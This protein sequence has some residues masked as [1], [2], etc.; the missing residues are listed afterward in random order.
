MTGRAGYTGDGIPGI[1]GKV[2]KMADVYTNNPNPLKE[3]VKNAPKL[4]PA[5]LEAL[6]LQKITS[7]K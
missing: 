5:M 4:D 1:L 6:A 2:Q 3:A 7:E